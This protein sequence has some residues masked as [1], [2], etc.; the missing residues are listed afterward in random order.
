MNIKNERP[1]VTI[2]LYVYNGEKYIKERLKNIFLQDFNN[3]ELLISDNASN[4]NTSRICKEFLK[5]DKRIRYIK[6]EKTIDIQANANFVLKNT[7]SKYFVW[8]QVDDLWEPEFLEEN[9]KILEKNPNIIGSSS[10]VEIIGSI[11]DSLKESKN[12]TVFDKLYKK[13]RKK[14]R[15]MDT[16]SLN[17]DFNQRIRKFLKNPGHNNVLFGVFRTKEFQ[18]SVFPEIFV[19]NDFCIVMNLL[20][21]GKIQV[22]NRVLNYKREGG[23]SGYGIINIIKYVKG[24]KIDYL[25]PH[26]ALTKWCFSNLPRKTFIKN[27]DQ[28]FKINLDAEFALFLNLIRLLFIESKIKVIY[29]K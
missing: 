4:D 27:L 3:F 8:T 25:F 23:M 24:N 7:K 2:G 14:F 6:Q 26:F 18:Q 13:I 19:G 11:T 21:I 29:N 15:K 16:Q 20:K 10:K 22:V 1:I 12:D 9:I 5:K 28:F 17:E